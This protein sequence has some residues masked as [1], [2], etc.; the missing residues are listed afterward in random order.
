MDKKP[1]G[2][3]KKIESGSADVNKGRKVGTSGPVGGGGRNGGSGSRMPGGSGGS[4][5]RGT[6][7]LKALPKLNFKTILIIAAIVVVGFIIL[8]ACGGS[9][10]DLFPSG[11]NATPS[12]PDNT[13]YVD[14]NDAQ[15]DRSVSSLARNKYYVPENGDKVTIMVYMCGTDLESKYGMA[16][17]DLSE[18]AKATIGSNVN[19]IVETGGCKEWKTQGISNTK[20]Q[21]YQVVSGGIRP[22]ESDFGSSAMTDPANLTKFI[23]YCEDKFPA[24]RNILI[25]WDHGGGSLSG[26]GYDE[27]NPS[28][29]S[30]TLAKIS[31]ALRNADCKFDFIG[32]DACLMATLETAL[33][34]E[35]YADYLVASEETEPGTGWYYTR[36][37]TELSANTSK[38]TIDIAKTIIDDFITSSTNASASAKVTLSIVDLAELNGTVP[39]A[40]NDF[41][42]DTTNIIKSDG[43]KQVSEARAGVRQFSS[44]NKINQVDL[45]DLAERIGTSDSKELA[46]VLK[47][48]VKYNRTSMSRC[49]GIS[50]Y[51]PYETTNSMNSAVASYDAIGLDDDYTKCIKSF[52][53]LELGGQVTAAATQTPASSSS[54]D[55]GSLLG[56]IT[57]GSSTSPVDAL[58]G[59]F[60]GGGST[61][62]AGFGIDA[63]T[64][65]GLLGSFSGRSMP[66]DL[67]WAD[68][69]L[70]AD[71]AEKIASGFIDPSHLVPTEKNGK[72]V[73]SLTESEWELISAVEINVFVDDGKGFIDLGL[74]NAVEYDGD[75]LVLGF[76]GTW[77]TINDN[78]CSFT[79]VS[80]DE[81]NGVYV[82]HIPALLNKSFVNIQV[83][84]DSKGETVTGAFPMYNDGTDVQAKGM[85][86]IKKGDEIELLCDYYD[87]D[88]K[89]NATY[90]LGNK[91]T[92]D[93]KGFKI[94]NKELTSKDV[95]VMYRLTDIYGNHF[96]VNAD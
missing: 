74:D 23:N 34:C 55:L 26:Y 53:S 10:F 31:T 86:E 14:Y 60:L 79:I 22:V 52:A 65:V 95:S 46:S 56:T 35:D 8:K 50:I 71:N 32:F 84:F 92:Y 29:S 94:V 63:S 61:S 17:S 12:E 25:F 36:W 45:V 76:D 41:A 81:K 18:M 43:Y 9:I 38:P 28:S 66:S 91:F 93:G 80:S 49:N 85:I 5:V 24:D 57:G 19:I 59:S 90:T 42:V 48:C 89:Y 47:S 67:A 87:Y 33:V 16:S 78:V 27:K 6:G 37:V 1:Q 44:Q 7:A 64:I 62:S 83:V 70:I 15:V 73:L 13:N 69:E 96:W 88:G 4:P 40:F 3:N 75:D 77:L 58:L 39:S 20:N 51:F 54:F 11:N 2:R 72:K 21:I 68:T 30:M 82:A